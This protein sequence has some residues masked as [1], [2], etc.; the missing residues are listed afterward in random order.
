MQNYAL[1]VSNITFFIHYYTLKNKTEEKS[2]YHNKIMGKFMN[3]EI[4][5]INN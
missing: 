3:M 4:I 1:E 5:D 2:M